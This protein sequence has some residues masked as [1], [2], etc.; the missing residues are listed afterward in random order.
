MKRLLLATPIGMLATFGLFVFMSFLIAS[1]DAR[2]D[3]VEKTVPVEINQT[4][5]DQ[6]V[7]ER[8]RK[9]VE[10][11]PPKPR[12][13]A[14]R[15]AAEPADTEIGSF[16]APKMAISNTG[17]SQP[18][19]A[20]GG[21]RESRPIVRIQPQYPVTAARD[22]IEGWVQLAF[23]VNELGGVIN[24]RIIDSYPKRI[25]DKAARKA[26]RKWKYQPK[27]DEGKAMIQKDMVVQ[28]DF[29]MDNII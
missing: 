23:D 20:I 2:V 16:A 10:P 17:L 27:M 25:F 24:I 8:P 22:G 18:A 12:P 5:P 26:L 21:D 6:K 1:E 4:P 3:I 9:L 28:L 11:E 19:F 7:H 29:K 14:Q 13:V 15:V